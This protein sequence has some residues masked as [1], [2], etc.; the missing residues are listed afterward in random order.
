[1]TGRIPYLVQ[2]NSRYYARLVVP[3][4]L[5]AIVGKS[6]LWEALDANR[7]EAIRMLPAAVARMQTTID[8][9][10]IQASVQPDGHKTRKTGKSLTVLQIA[11]VHYASE[12]AL[13]EAARNS[14]AYTPSFGTAAY[15]GKLSLI[16]AGLEADIETI[17]AAIG[18]AISS[19]EADTKTPL[20]PGSPEWRSLARSLAQVQ[21]EAIKRVEERDLGDFNGV[22]TLPILKDPLPSAVA[23]T[24]NDPTHAR[25]LCS[26]SALPLKQ[27]VL[28]FLAER[29]ISQ[30]SQH[31]HLVSVRMFEEF[32]GE[33]KPAHQITRRDLIEYKNALLQTPANYVK[34]FPGCSLPDAIK[35][36]KERK[37][38]YA[39][40]EPVTIN[41][42]WISALRALLNWCV[43]N[44]LLPDNPAT[45]IKASFQAD[46]GE[47]KRVNF[48]PSDLAK[49][50]AKPLFDRAKPW[51]ETQWAYLLSL[52]CGTRPSELAQVK[53]D[54]VRHEQ[55]ALVIIVQERAKNVRSHR[56]IPIHP[57][58]IRLGLNEYVSALRTKGETHL[59][60]D[61]YR[62]GEQS[63]KSAQ[64]RAN[65]QPTS[66]DKHFPKF[67][68]KRFNV[69]FRRKVGI[70][71]KRKVFYSFR[72]TFKTCLT[73]SGA[74]KDV[75]D[76]LTGHIKKD[77]SQIYVHGVSMER[78]VAAIT[79]LRFDGLDLG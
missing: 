79:R 53:L 13:D 68:P 1:M 9:A 23:P 4:P 46:T 61:W 64:K 17:T 28:K 54:S 5:R 11:R 41:D 12:L 76:Y 65:G 72:H 3:K 34:R 49:I 67:I 51:G 39:P 57:D 42:K 6:E 47:A 37:V 48:E 33:P 56:A 55:G 16:A 59:F 73:V 71:D 19:F 66:L 50:F 24:S 10:R 14:G 29:N 25:L 78:M 63:A 70:T 38:P 15:H 75:C 18:W 26:D 27:L 45:G 35:A 2:Q 74:E 8:M 21:M 52:Y 40:L 62:D 60:P 22:P 7:R 69:T 31:E 44:D 58:L 20:E 30:A 32:L 43:Q 77:P 36:N